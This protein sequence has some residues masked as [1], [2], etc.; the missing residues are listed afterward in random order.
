MNN[1]KILNNDNQQIMIIKTKGLSLKG[2][3]LHELVELDG[4]APETP[5][6]NPGV[7]LRIA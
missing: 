1:N 2:G 4:C 5:H 7:F 6:P 3:K